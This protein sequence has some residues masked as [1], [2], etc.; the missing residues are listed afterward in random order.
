MSG[1][2]DWESCRSR[3]GRRCHRGDARDRALSPVCAHA[4]PH[5]ETRARAGAQQRRRSHI[6]RVFSPTRDTRRVAERDHLHV[7][8]TRES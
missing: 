3:N 2:I 8:T 7:L 4:S 5:P 1:L 6:P